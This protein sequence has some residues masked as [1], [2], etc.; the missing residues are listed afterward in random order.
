MLLQINEHEHQLLL[1]LLGSALYTLREVAS[2]Y[3]APA[4]REGHVPGSGGF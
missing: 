2:E 4:L 1:E 3:H